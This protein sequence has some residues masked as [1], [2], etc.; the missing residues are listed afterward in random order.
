MFFHLPNH[1]IYMWKT[2]YV[3]LY[4]H[5]DTFSTLYQTNRTDVDAQRM[6]PNSSFSSFH[7]IIDVHKEVCV[8][9]MT[10]SL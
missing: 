9:K 6:L 8:L 1:I 10:M 3:I 4:Q 7:L 2:I 5:I